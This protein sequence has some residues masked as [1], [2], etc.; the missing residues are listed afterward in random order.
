MFLYI[1]VQLTQ[2]LL[3]SSFILSMCNIGHGMLTGLFF[4]PKHLISLTHP[5]SFSPSLE[6]NYICLN[7]HTLLLI[8]QHTFFYLLCFGYPFLIVSS[9]L[10]YPWPFIWCWVDQSHIVLLIQSYP[11]WWTCRW[12]LYF[13]SSQWTMLSR[14]SFHMAFWG[15][16]QEFLRNKATEKNRI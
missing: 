9:N 11:Y 14:P 13:F 8:L 1:C 3:F 4:I 12:V 16:E 7:S 10:L 15:H 6:Q 2:V 5:V